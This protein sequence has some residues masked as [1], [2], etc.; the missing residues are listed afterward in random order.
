MLTEGEIWRGDVEEGRE[1]C[2]VVD[3]EDGGE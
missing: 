2:M 3:R 1:I